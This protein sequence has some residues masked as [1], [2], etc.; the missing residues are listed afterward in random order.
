MKGI[1]ELEARFKA[2]LLAALRR[3]AGGRSPAL[4]SLSGHRPRSAARSLQQKAERIIELRQCYSVDQ[5]AVSPAADYLAACLKWE[6][7]SAH[8]ERSVR[9]AAQS[10]MRDLERHAV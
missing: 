2:E 1:D 6:H 5:S 7:G 3:A 4:F 10:L 9:E 8:D